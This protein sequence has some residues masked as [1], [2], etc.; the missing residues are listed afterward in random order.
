M[1]HLN[2]ILLSSKCKLPNQERKNM[3]ANVGLIR[4]AI[5]PQTHSLPQR[6]FLKSQN[7]RNCRVADQTADCYFPFIRTADLNN[8]YDVTFFQLSTQLSSM[9][10]KVFSNASYPY[11]KKYEVQ[12]HTEQQKQTSKK[13][14]RNK[15]VEKKVLDNQ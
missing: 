6:R 1:P 3:E 13:Y 15:R 11:A 14:R 4:P 12:N 7:N 8:F 5:A 9:Y 10:N 2:P